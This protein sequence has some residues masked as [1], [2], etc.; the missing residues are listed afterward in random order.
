M[1]YPKG[2][3]AKNRSDLTGKVF[4]R[5]T[6]IS[7]VDTVSRRSRWQCRCEC[8]NVKVIAGK[9][10]SNG[11]SQS[12]GCTSRGY[13]HGQHKNRFYYVYSGMLKRCYNAKHEAY[14]RYG[15]RGIKV[16]EEWL[17]DIKTFVAWCEAK[18]PADGL[19]LDRRN[20]DGDYAPNNCHFVT[21]KLQQRNMRSN[22]NIEF[23]GVTMIYKDF[24]AKHGVVSYSTACQRVSKQKMDRLQAA[25]T[26]AMGAKK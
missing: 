11:H 14:S 3:V 15:G 13:K 26:P 5:L 20:N 16:C 12:C 18:N 4:G 9:E 17:A 23:N 10:L 2:Q 24:V 1:S 19:T 25:L 8:G 21:K 6:V 7:Y 22:V